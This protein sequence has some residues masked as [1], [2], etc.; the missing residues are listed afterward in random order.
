VSTTKKKVRKKKA[1]KPPKPDVPQRELDQAVEFNESIKFV[2]NRETVVDAVTFQ[3]WV[4]DVLPWAIDMEPCFDASWKTA[5]QNGMIV[6]DRRLIRRAMPTFAYESPPMSF[7]LP[8]FL[9]PSTFTP[10]LSWRRQQLFT[11]QGSKQGHVVFTDEVYFPVLR[12]SNDVVMSLTPM[13]VMSQR[14]GLR[15]ARGNVIMGGLGLGWLA[16]RVLERK[17]VK[18]LTVVDNDREVIRV[19]GEP[20]KKKFGDKLLLL[21]GD[22]YETALDDSAKYDTVLADIWNEYG[23]ASY[24]RRF[25]EVK[26]K[27]ERVWGWGDYA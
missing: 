21:H 9:L 10:S 8:A 1:K 3:M 17:Q 25:K 4:D 11:V 23:E 15:K 22:F 2:P 26:A 27:Y 12:D 5:L 7:G 19:F 18:H 13:E 24:N 14:A 6:G 20:L 16:L